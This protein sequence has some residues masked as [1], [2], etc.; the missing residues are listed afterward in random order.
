MKYWLWGNWGIQASMA[1]D[2]R[3]YVNSRGHLG[4][5]RDQKDWVCLSRGHLDQSCGC[6]PWL[7]NLIRIF[8]TATLWVNSHIAKLPSTRESMLHRLSNTM[9]LHLSEMFPVS[10]CIYILKRPGSMGCYDYSFKPKH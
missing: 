1:A 7:L 6:H 4:I 5:K 10:S 9:F 3:S 2:K 8:A